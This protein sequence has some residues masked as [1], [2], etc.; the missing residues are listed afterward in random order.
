M[1]S[2][3]KIGAFALVGSCATAGCAGG[4]Y[5]TSG[6]P[7]KDLINEEYEYILLDTT[8]G[9]GNKDETKWGEVWNS[10]KTNSND[11]FKLTGW[12]ASK[13]DLNLKEELKKR[14]N[15]LSGSKVSNK[16][17]DLYKHVTKYCSRGVTFEEQAKKDRLNVLDTSGATHATI[18]SNRHRDKTS[19]NAHLTKL[20]ITSNNSDGSNIKTGCNTAKAKNKQVE[21]Y[22]NVYAS[23]KEVCIKKAGD[24]N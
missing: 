16:E 15:E 3:A 8:A 7:I 14:C 10:Y 23:F 20:G 24:P 1:A 18:W 13:T 21:D 9:S 5:L 22:S 4:I 17:S 19:I 2:P 6:T 11:I 12:D